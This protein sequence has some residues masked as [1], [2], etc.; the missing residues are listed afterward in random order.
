VDKPYSGENRLLR[1][2]GPDDVALLQPHLKSVEL[3]RG[4]VL[5]RPRGA[6]EHVYFP[7]RGMVSLLVVLK[8][9]QEIETAIIGREGV[10]LRGSPLG[11]FFMW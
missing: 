7:L 5:H 8:T 10:V 4:D 2:L 9:G 11:G 3:R 6:I 1:S